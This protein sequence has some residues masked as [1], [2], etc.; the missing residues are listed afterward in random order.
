MRAQTPD[1]ADQ[2]ARWLA[3]C[4]ALE[5]D[6]LPRRRRR[7]G[8]AARRAGRPAARRLP[9]ASSPS[10][11]AAWAACG[12]RE[13]SDGRFEGQVAIKLLNA[14]LVGR[15]GEERFAREGRIL[16]RLAH[17]H[18]A[19]LLDAGVTRQRPALPGARVRRGRADRPLLR[20]AA[21]RRRRAACACSSTCWRAVA[22]AHAN[23]VVHRDLK[24]SNILVTPAGQVKLLDFGIAKLL[25]AG[26]HGRPGDRADAR[27]RRA[28]TP[29][30]AAPEQV[31]GGEVTTATDVYAL[32]VL[33]YVLL[34]GRHPAAARSTTRPAA[35]RVV[36]RSLADVEAAEPPRDVGRPSGTAAAARELAARRPRHHRREGAEEARRRALPRGRGAGRRPAPLPRPRAHHRA[37]RRLRLPW[38]KFVRRHRVAV[39]LGAP[40]PWPPWPA[41]PARGARRPERRPSATSP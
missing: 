17:P 23:L 19:R 8:A 4:E 11:T 36:T 41:S 34:A 28:L 1:L 32:G 37:P 30:Y 3:E 31:Q 33:L 40:R 22:H 16:A 10:A 21:P 25:D 13:R 38:R 15:G 26:R 29:E 35:A 2:I 5:R 12:W 24:P 14:A 18:I 7:G 39:A 27:G 6:G 9:A 20:R